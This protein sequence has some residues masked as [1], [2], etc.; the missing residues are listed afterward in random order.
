MFHLETLRLRRNKIQDAA[1]TVSP[2]E[3]APLSCEAEIL[4]SLY[5]S[6]DEF[7]EELCNTLKATMMA[8]SD[9]LNATSSTIASFC[10]QTR[11]S[12][13]QIDTVADGEPGADPASVHYL[14][15]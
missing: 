3:A 14:P 13:A 8:Y 9:C 4:L 1:N 15:C 2:A 11:P 10:E 7:S 12:I 6:Y 5:Q